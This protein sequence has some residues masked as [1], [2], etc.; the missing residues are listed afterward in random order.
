MRSRY[1]LCAALCL[2]VVVTVACGPARQA[3]PAAPPAGP[4]QIFAIGDAVEIG[5]FRITVNKTRTWPGD[6]WNDPGEG[7]VWF[8]IE[9]TLE[10]RNPAA[11]V[12]VNSWVNFQL[13][14][15]DGRCK[16][17]AGGVGATGSLDGEIAAGRRMTGELSWAV[18]LGTKG[19]ELVFKPG[20]PSGVGQAIFALGDLPVAAAETTPPVGPPQIFAI[21]DAAEIEGF[22]ITVNKTRTWRGDQWNNPG[23]GH[24]WF[25]VE[26]TLENT[27]PTASLT[28]WSWDN[29]QLVDEDGR[30]KGYATNVGAT[31]TLD[32][33]IAPG[34]RMTG[35]ISWAVP[36][37][38]KG[39]ELVFVTQDPLGARVQVVFALGDL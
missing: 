6:Q 2:C 36:V 4:V 12:M 14:D 8:I 20:E 26:S 3:T 28:V 5:D 31:G 34:R 32:G 39:L 15:E 1:L 37:G 13:V 23:E 18:P 7:R 22:R 35:E 17:Y 10:N 33:D 38:T 29:F 9:C 11:S 19:L 16:G 24:V 30:C 21:G 27:S 25:I